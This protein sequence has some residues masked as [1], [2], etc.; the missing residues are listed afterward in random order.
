M[1]RCSILKNSYGMLEAPDV[2]T[3]K[4]GL[5]SF[6]TKSSVLNESESGS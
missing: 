4:T 2:G 6:I 1:F 3:G 5:S